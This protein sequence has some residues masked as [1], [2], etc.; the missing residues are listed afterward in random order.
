M[1]V[2]CQGREVCSTN[3]LI[4]VATV[5]SRIEGAPMTIGLRGHDSCTSKRLDGIRYL[6]RETP[7]LFKE[8]AVYS[9]EDMDLPAPPYIEYFD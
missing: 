9:G 5:A 6:W 4:W 3:D 1:Q 2:C 7:C 8:A